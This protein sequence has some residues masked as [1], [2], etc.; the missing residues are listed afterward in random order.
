MGSKER[1]ERQKVMLRREI[2]DAAME[3]FAKEGYTHVSMRKIANKI[4]YSPTIIYYYFKDK[5]HLLN[6]I[7]D[8]TFA[9]LIKGFEA[10][11]PN[12]S[13]PLTCLRTGLRVYVDFGLKHPNH[14]QVAFMAC[15]AGTG[16]YNFE[17][18]VYEEAF[19]FIRTAVKECVRQNKV[20]K[21]DIEA[22]SQALWVAAH[23]LTS[24]LIVDK[25]FPWINQDK[26]INYLIDLLIKGMKHSQKHGPQG[27]EK[28]KS[29]R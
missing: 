2:L 16:R 26:L 4:E 3:M 6:C 13:D 25:D 19:N 27:E 29:Q 10:L 28:A 21:L 9:E 14:Y 7:C 20:R 15:G 22:T 18:S 8:D 23:G 24:L 1:I 12:F 11:R 17:G 5:A